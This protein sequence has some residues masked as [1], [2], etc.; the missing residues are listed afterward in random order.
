LTENELSSTPIAQGRTAE[1]FFWDDQHVLKLYRDWCPADWVD[2]E[3]RIAHAIHAAGIPSPAPGDIIEINGRRG[4][5]YERLEGMSMLEDM[6][7]RPWRVLKHARSLAELH[8]QIHQQSITG[9]PSYKD[10]LEYDIRDNAHLSNELKTKAL[11]R[12][13][14]FSHDEK[15]CHGDYHPG[16]VLITKNGPVVIDWMTASTG[17]PWTDVARTSLL[18]SI[19][20][21]AADKQVHPMIRSAIRFFHRTY[22]NRYRAL[23]PEPDNELPR[24]MPVI[25][26]ARLNE[27]IMPERQALIKIVVEGLAE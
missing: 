20:A 12:L 15:V 13:A 16:N 11:A 5:V 26:A 19:G 8:V 7:A 27:N 6:N 1:I 3:A 25:A 10:R 18:L 14:S 4:L 23:N 24:W 2:Y 21:R 22:L 17:S 9:L